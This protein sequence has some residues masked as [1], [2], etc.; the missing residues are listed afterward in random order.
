MYSIYCLKDLD[1]KIKY[2]GQTI[3]PIG[4]RSSHKREKPPHTFHV[5]YENLEREQAKNLE[6]HLISK[7]ETYGNGWNLSPGGEGFEDYS[8][9]GIG[10][11]PK[12]TTPWNKN[13]KNAFSKETK[14]RW[15]KIRKGK[16]WKPTKMTKEDVIQLRKIFETKPEI[17]GVGVIQKNGRAMSYIQAFSLKYSKDY[18]VTPQNIKNIVLRKTW[19]DV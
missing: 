13:V 14:E 17:E 19:K 9:K 10:G 7:F 15:S 12:G 3:N 6:I 11:V 18:Q 5:L 1:E 8:R 4:R 16:C 2:V